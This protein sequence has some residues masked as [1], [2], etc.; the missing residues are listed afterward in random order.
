[1]EKEEIEMTG[2][3]EKNQ[4]QEERRDEMKQNVKE[5]MEKKWRDEFTLRTPNGQ[6]L[7]ENLI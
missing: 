4:H 2:K 1:M 6:E 3:E 7:F 5:V